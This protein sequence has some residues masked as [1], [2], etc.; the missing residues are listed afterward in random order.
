[1]NFIT[2]SVSFC[3]LFSGCSEVWRKD[4]SSSSSS[5]STQDSVKDAK[6]G[7]VSKNG[8]MIHYVIFDDR[9]YSIEVADQPQGPGSKWQDAKSAAQAHSACIA[10]NAGFFD[11]KGKPVGWCV[12]DQQKTGYNNKTA[13]GVG[14]VQV[15]KKGTHLIVHREKIDVKSAQHLL[16]AGPFLRKNYKVNAK[17]AS[18]EARPRSFIAWDGAY[19]WMIGYAESATLYSLSKALDKVQIEGFKMKTALNLDGGRSSQFY[20][21]S[22]VAEN[23][24]QVQSFMNRKVRN[25]L[26]VKKR[27]ISRDLK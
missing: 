6:S 10:I 25:F 3:L 12:D 9:E 22:E 14:A 19:T 15:S 23:E 16:Q 11:P 1:M 26:V 13:L 21:S 24:K 7:V 18:Y 17:L 4:S 8:V 27:K 2:S 5:T 20:L